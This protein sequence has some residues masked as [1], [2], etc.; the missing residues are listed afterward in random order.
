MVET[1]AT[2]HFM[3]TTL[4]LKYNKENDVHMLTLKNYK[5]KKFSCAI[6]PDNYMNFTVADPQCNFLKYLIK[7]GDV[8]IRDESTK[9]NIR[10]WVVVEFNLQTQFFTLNTL[11]I[12][13]EFVENVKQKAV[14]NIMPFNGV[15]YVESVT[16]YPKI[17][18]EYST[19][20]LKLKLSDKFNFKLSNDELITLTL[21]FMFSINQFIRLLINNKCILHFEFFNSTDT[22]E[23][24]TT[25]DDANKCVCNIEFFVNGKDNGI[26][27]FQL[28][29]DSL[30]Y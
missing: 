29:S 8:T 9:T 6:F 21:P 15:L 24:Q 2:R 25:F 19:H 22:T 23:I 18:C 1:L 3:S 28:G 13:L 17:K 7:K 26:F 5:N 30:L 4:K 16:D 10:N 20:D 12:A 27:K 14:E 11:E